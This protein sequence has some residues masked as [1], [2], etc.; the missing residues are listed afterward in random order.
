[1]RGERIETGIGRRQPIRSYEDIEACQRAMALLPAVHT[2]AASFPEYERYELASQMP[3]ASKSIP[4][5]I[6]EGYG[7]RSS[8]KEFKHYL[9]NALGSA[10]EM[11]VHIRVARSLGYVGEGEARGLVGGYDIV[12]KQLARLMETWRQL[13]P[14]TSHVSRPKSRMLGEDSQ[15]KPKRS[16]GEL[17]D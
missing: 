5:N 2:L 14:L 11:I 8:V 16:G 7:K 4:A 12:G 9:A 3:R 1:V 15:M 17:H 10:N 6:A 13:P